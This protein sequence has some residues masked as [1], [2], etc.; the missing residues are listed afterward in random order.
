MSLL[1]VPQGGSKKI[2]LLSL[3][4]LASSKESPNQV[5]LSSSSWGDVP[6]VTVVLHIYIYSRARMLRA[7]VGGAT[8]LPLLAEHDRPK[9]VAS[10]PPPR[11]TTAPRTN[12]RGR[13]KG[14]PY[15]DEEPKAYLRR[16]VFAACVASQFHHPPPPESEFLDLCELTHAHP[17]RPDLPERGGERDA[18]K[19]SPSRR[20]GGCL[21]ARDVETA[22]ASS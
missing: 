13:M 4:S 10:T 3:Y 2:V 7:G 14:R 22:W 20:L 17:K 8:T 11:A 18:G 5:W 9:D 6:A 15:R 19:T 12:R 1:M 21:G 16:A